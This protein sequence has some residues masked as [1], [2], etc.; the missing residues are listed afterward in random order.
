LNGKGR[1]GEN[2]F[3]FFASQSKQTSISLFVQYC[4]PHILQVVFLS[5]SLPP[6][7]FGGQQLEVKLDGKTIAFLWQRDA[8]AEQPLT[9]LVGLATTAFPCW[10]A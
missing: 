10:K 4:F 7:P 6:S 1:K 8:H 5:I 2:N 3:Y 9:H